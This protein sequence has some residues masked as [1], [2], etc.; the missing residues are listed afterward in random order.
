MSEN[1]ITWFAYASSL[2]FF[3]TGYPQS[4]KTIIDTIST[5]DVYVKQI[6]SCF[7]GLD[8]NTIY[9]GYISKTEQM[10]TAVILS[11]THCDFFSVQYIDSII[12]LNEGIRNYDI[13]SVVFLSNDY[14]VSHD[15]V[16]TPFIGFIII[17]NKTILLYG[18]PSPDLKLVDIETMLP[19]ELVGSFIDILKKM[20]LC[21]NRGRFVGRAHSR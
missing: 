20:R 2:L 5:N 9:V 16:D 7:S 12:S 11:D 3:G 13:L 21:S 10:D 17:R 14:K 6:N 15:A 19:M 8:T 4:N 18:L 1:I